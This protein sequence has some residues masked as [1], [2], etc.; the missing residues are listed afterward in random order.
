MDIQKRLDDWLAANPDAQHYVSAI[1]YVPE[2]EDAPAAVTHV[3]RVQS[4]QSAE[5]V[6]RIGLAVVPKFAAFLDTLLAMI[7]TAPPPPPS[8]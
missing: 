5:R 7:A 3:V 6:L 1:Y 2:G 4:Q 8:A